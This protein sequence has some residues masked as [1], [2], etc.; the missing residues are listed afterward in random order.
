MEIE[1]DPAKSAWNEAERGIPFSLAA[2]FD[3]GS[4]LVA[5]DTR[6]DYGE[7]RFRAIGRI[8]DRLH[9]LIY[10]P[11]GETLRVVSLRKANARER[12]AYAQAT[13]S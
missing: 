10:T 12:K 5:K 4:A 1:F 3:L 11:R 13:R 6:E 8:G 9:V 7:D 2:Q